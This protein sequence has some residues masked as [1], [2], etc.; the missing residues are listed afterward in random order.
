MLLAGIKVD[1]SQQDTLRCAACACIVELD[2]AAALQAVCHVFLCA[3]DIRVFTAI[4][5]LRLEAR[6]LLVCGR[7]NESHHIVLRLHLVGR[8]VVIFHPLV[9]PV[10]HL[11]L[12]SIALDALAVKEDDIG[13]PYELTVLTCRCHGLVV[14]GLDRLV[15]V[16]TYGIERAAGCRGWRLDLVVGGLVDI[17][18]HLCLR[19]CLIP[20]DELDDGCL[21][22]IECIAFS[23]LRYPRAVLV[24]HLGLALRPDCGERVGEDDIAQEQVLAIISWSGHGFVVYTLRTCDIDC[25]SCRGYDI[26]IVYA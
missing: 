9:I 2:A 19:A 3:D 1:D 22:D 21:L 8:R 14:D 13:R 18:F 11:H 7:V 20:V 12:A 6:R 24:L 26:D 5:T 17:D 23:C 10:A 25:L 16:E 15:L 4:G